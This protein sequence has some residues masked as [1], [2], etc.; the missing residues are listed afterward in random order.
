MMEYKAYLWVEVVE[1][2][3]RLVDLAIVNGTPD[4]LP[5]VDKRFVLLRSQVGFL[6]E[7]GGCLRVALHGEVIEDQGIDVT[8]PRCQRK[9]PAIG[10]ARCDGI[11]GQVCN[12]KKGVVL[13]K[14]RLPWIYQVIFDSACELLREIPI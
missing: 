7:V 2:G 4:L 3:D 13:A 5:C 8:G 6:G 9:D 1:E 14:I 12:D 10:H 11:M